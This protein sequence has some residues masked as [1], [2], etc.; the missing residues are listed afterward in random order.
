MKMEYTNEEM[1][2]MHLVYGMAHCN[3]TEAR[4]LYGNM[5]PNRQLPNKKTFQRI[6]ERLRN[7]GCFKKMVSDNGRPNRV[8][9]L[10]LEERIL[11]HIEVDPGIST[12]RVAAE[13]N[14]GHAT[15]WRVLRD[16]LLHP[17]HLQRVQSLE[18]PDFPPRMEFCNWFLEMANQDRN[19]LPSVLFTDEAGFSRDGIFNFHNTH[20]WAEENPHL[21]HQSRHQRKFS[22]NVW[23]GIIGDH[24]I[25][26]YFFEGALTGQ[27]YANFLEHE[28]PQL[29]E[30][31]PLNVRQ[32]MWFM[33][34][35]A[36]PHFSVVARN[37][38][39][40]IFPNR[41]IGRGGQWIWPARS[42]DLNPLDFYLWGHSKA[43]V[44]SSP[45]ENIE[46]LRQRIR[47]AFQQ[48]RETPD[49][50]ERVR[51]SMIRRLQA[52]VDSHGAHF[53]HLL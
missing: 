8:R 3:A 9:T 18:E 25:G 26:P 15:V 37:T 34:D 41:W 13:E 39:N 49:I 33:H 31:V 36:P 27:F 21:I 2:D 19:F 32:R 20:C 53:E 14:I 40:E 24:L 11:R 29:L 28:L 30:N 50:F 46:V 38:L 12:R 23:A 42:P 22:V 4:R 52:C 7:R 35:G 48:I 6:H 16:Q 17:Y 5:F 47:G 44:Y 43:L 45:I 10:Q 51:G 1:T